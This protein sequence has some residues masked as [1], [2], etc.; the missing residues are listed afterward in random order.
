MRF[1]RQLRTYAI[2]FVLL[3]LALSGTAL[4]DEFTSTNYRL[5]DPVL[6]PSGYGT[7]S[8]FQLWGSI[9][10]TAVGTSTSSGFSAIGGFLPFPFASTPAVSATAGATQV[11]LSWTS[12]Q[13][14]LGWNVGS[15]VVGQSTS[16]GGPYTYTSAGLSTSLTQTSLTAGTVYYFVVTVRD[17]FG[18]GI[19]TSSE[20]SATPTSGSPGGGGGG[21]GGGGSGGGG[22]ASIFVSGSAYPNSTIYFYQDGREILRTVSGPDAKFEFSKSNIASGSYTFSVVAV[23]PKKQRS[24]AFSIPVTLPEDGT[25]RITGVFLAPTLATDYD[26]VKRGETITFFGLTVPDAGVVLQV[27]SSEPHFFQASSDEDG[28]YLMQFNSGVLELGK[29]TAKSQAQKSAVMSP[30]SNLVAFKVS[31]E[32]QRKVSVMKG[33]L[34]KDGRVNL[35]DFSIAAYWYK[36]TLTGTIITDEIERLNGDGV[37]NLTDFSIIAYYWTN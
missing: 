31:D 17:A 9:G 13:T 7:S 36:R 29:H 19:A 12:S 30:Y 33:D 5:L 22:T 37:I 34:N 27:N 14:Y 25:T 35:Y 4:A 2:S 28:V 16:T 8:S 20:V 23:D 3:L 6:A 24:P 21:G 18:N 32:T 11:A 1:G 26:Q 10:E 15:Y